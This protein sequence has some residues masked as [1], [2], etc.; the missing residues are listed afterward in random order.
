[1]SMV[2]IDSE[3][4]LAEAVK[5]YGSTVNFD[6]ETWHWLPFWVMKSE[7]GLFLVPSEE[8]PRYVHDMIDS[9]RHHKKDFPNFKKPMLPDESYKL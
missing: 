1:M 4:E 3:I 7:A 8:L 9:M 6:V 2:K 5:H